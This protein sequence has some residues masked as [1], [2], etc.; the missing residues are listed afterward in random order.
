MFLRTHETKLFTDRQ[1]TLAEL[2]RNAD[3]YTQGLGENVA[4]VGRRRVGKTLVLQKFADELLDRDQPILPIYFNVERNMTLPPIFA[5]RFFATVGNTCLRITG[6]SSNRSFGLPSLTDLL[7]IAYRSSAP[8]LIETGE[9]LMRE[10]EKTRADERLMLELAFECLNPLA[11]DLEQEVLVI[12]DE[13]Q[14]ITDFDRYPQIRNVLGLLRGIMAG[15][16]KVHYIVAGSSVRMLE[17]IFQQA[18]SPLF[19]QFRTLSLPPFGRA[20][21]ALLLRKILPQQ[22]VSAQVVGQVYSFTD[23]YPFY[24]ACL[25]STI[26][27]LSESGVITSEVVERAIYTETMMKTGRIYQYCNYILETS[28]RSARGQ[29][30]LRSVMLLLADEGPMTSSQAA[31]RL[32]RQAGQVNNYF[33]RLLD[34]DL[35]ERK[36]NNYRIADP[37]LALWIKYALLES[38]TE[39]ESFRRSADVYLAQLRERVEALSTELGMA[40]ESVARELLVQLGGRAVDGRWFGQSGELAIPDFERVGDYCSEDGQVEVDVLAE[41]ADSEHPAGG[42]RW[43]VEVKWRNRAVGVKELEA[44]QGKA[45]KLRGQ[46]WYIS[47]MGFTAQALKWAEARDM[48]LST[49]ADLQSLQRLVED[50]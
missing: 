45:E 21:T 30:T 8:S 38:A 22:Q 44:L 42:E 41:R 17:Q 9:R 27:Q 37:V 1:S 47:R 6:Q 49:A 26:H 11:A 14:A 3:R 33:R 46:G 34:Y 31:R 29:T 39:Y 40:Q 32:R 50:E 7:S 4:L 25:G 23:G 10:T 20:D 2:H 13:F 19:G 36:Q 48:L 43:V 15:Q 12:L 35:V 18:E 5:S 28:L 16:D 24:V